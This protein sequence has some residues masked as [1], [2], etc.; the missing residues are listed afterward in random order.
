[1]IILF[2]LALLY[3]TVRFFNIMRVNNETL[4]LAGDF[5][6]LN[7]RLHLLVAKKE[8]KADNEEFIFLR[9]LLCNSIQFLSS[10]NFWVIVYIAFKLRKV[11]VPPGDTELEE[12]FS[13]NKE[14]QYIL[15]EYKKLSQSYIY[16]KSKISIFVFKTTIKSIRLITSLF[17]RA[18][19]ITFLTNFKRVFTLTLL[20]QDDNVINWC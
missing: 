14:L 15:N 20:Q 12:K 9:T 4:K 16:S 8:I 11:G 7:T 17:N 5:S 2:S 13:H 6:A 19:G 3:G 10:L 1:M 18:R